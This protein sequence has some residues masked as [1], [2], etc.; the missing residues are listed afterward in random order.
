MSIGHGPRQGTML[1]L[2][3][4]RQVFQEPF[5]NSTRRSLSK[6]TQRLW[7]EAGSKIALLTGKSLANK[8][9]RKRRKHEHGFSP[10]YGIKGGVPFPSNPS[11]LPA[12]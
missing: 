4:P 12:R 7:L 5:N 3:Q 8:A 10:V 9:N 2:S 6:M 1:L 11:N